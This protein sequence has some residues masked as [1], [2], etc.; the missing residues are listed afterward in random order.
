M[1]IET[2]KVDKIELI[3]KLPQN[4]AMLVNWNATWSYRNRFL[5]GVWLPLYSP[6]IS[7]DEI[8][9]PDNFD[10]EIAIPGVEMAFILQLFFVDTNLRRSANK[11]TVKTKMIAVAITIDSKCRI[12]QDFDLWYLANSSQNKYKLQDEINIKDI[13][14]E[15]QMKKLIS[16]F[17]SKIRDYGK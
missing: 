8:Y 7:N 14:G 10:A 9:I 6:I 13:I 17:R 3:T 2:L 12:I 5:N 4:V 16:T 1:E 15:E 11:H